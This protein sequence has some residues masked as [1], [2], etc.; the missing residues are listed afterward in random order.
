MLERHRREV[1]VTIAIVALAGVLVIAAPGYFSR[2]NLSDLFLAN[3]P[4]LIVTLGMTLVVLTGE[5]DISVGSMFAICGVAA[6]VS[7]KWGLP[8]PVAGLIACV[9]GAALGAVNGALVAYV[10]IPSIVVTLAT[11]V[12]LRD[13]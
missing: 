5:I 9:I 1:S 8:V 11:M 4:V 12:A 7:A 10:R 13:G 6:G 3:M 2:E